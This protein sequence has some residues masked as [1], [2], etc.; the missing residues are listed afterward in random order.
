MKLGDITDIAV[1][2]LVAQRARMAAT[3]SNVANAQTTH[4]D[5]GGVYRRRDP[6][7]R[8]EPVGGPFAGRLERALHRV[9]VERVVLDARPPITR[10]EPGHPDADADGYVSLPR[11]NVVEE[12]SNMMSAARSYESNLIILR[13]VS[14]MKE[15]AMQIGR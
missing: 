5:S 6:V 1:S 9:E 15:A 7:F 11:V 12:L 13:K 14:E 4:T 8:T 3:A 10:F 2:G